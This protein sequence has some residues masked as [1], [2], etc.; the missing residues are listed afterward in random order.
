M[1]RGNAAILY[2]RMAWVPKLISA[3]L[4]L[5]RQYYLVPPKDQPSK[6]K[7]ISFA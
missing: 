3:R 1:H 7:L 5:G 4:S 6:Q 2:G